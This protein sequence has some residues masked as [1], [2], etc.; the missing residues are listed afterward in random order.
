MLIHVK[1]DADSKKLSK[2]VANTNPGDAINVADI[3]Q[4][5]QLK[6][7]IIEAKAVDLKLSLIDADGYVLKQIS[8][9]RRNNEKHN[10][11][12]NRFTDRQMSVISAL[13][14]IMVLLDK[15][16]LRLTGYSDELVVTK[17]DDASLQTGDLAI[18]IDTKDVYKGAI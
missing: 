1:P 16:G 6:S 7:L 9:K 10:Q 2:I 17:A 15:E 13:E 11:I 14:R 3:K 4:F 12:N 5:E 8:T 18:D